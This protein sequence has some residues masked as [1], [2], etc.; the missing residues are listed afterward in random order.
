M[1]MH[2]P[3]RANPRQVL[4][5]QSPSAFD[6]AFERQGVRTVCKERRGA[7]AR[8]GQRRPELSCRKRSRPNR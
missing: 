6:I 5:R 7:A 3:G 8:H 1:Q 4:K 2:S